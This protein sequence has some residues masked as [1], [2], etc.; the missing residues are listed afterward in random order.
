MWLSFLPDQIRIRMSFDTPMPSEVSFHLPSTVPMQY[1]DP[2]AALAYQK[3]VDMLGLCGP[4]P[5]VVMCT[6]VVPLHELVAGTA[7]GPATA[8]AA[9]CRMLTVLAAGLAACAGAGA[10]SIPSAG[11]APTA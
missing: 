2:P 9:R 8:P 3:V 1:P 10:I 7:C 11:A 6:S 5:L 4:K